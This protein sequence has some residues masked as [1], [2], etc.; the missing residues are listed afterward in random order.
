M[1]V[2]LYAY[3]AYLFKYHFAQLFQF[4]LDDFA[5]LFAPPGDVPHIPRNIQK[6]M[7]IP[8][9]FRALG[10]AGAQNGLRRISPQGG[11]AHTG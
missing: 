11:P 6:N 1:M 9:S 7:R 10:A 8:T 2:G 5:Y 4:I 3:C